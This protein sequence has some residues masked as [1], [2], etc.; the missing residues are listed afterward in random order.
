MQAQLGMGF[1][2]V[3]HQSRI[4]Q[5]NRIHAQLGGVVDRRDPAL[6]AAGLG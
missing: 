6:P 5:D 4:G 3:L 2:G 1:R